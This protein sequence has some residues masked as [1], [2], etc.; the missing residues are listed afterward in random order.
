[1]SKRIPIHPPSTAPT[2]K[3]KGGLAVM[4]VT[5]DMRSIALQ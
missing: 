4:R 3:V 1:M 2:V 5:L